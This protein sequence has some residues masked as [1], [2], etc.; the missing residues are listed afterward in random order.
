MRPTCPNWPT[1][2]RTPASRI[3]PRNTRKTRK[4]TEEQARNRQ[5]APHSRWLLSLSSFVS[6]VYF[7]VETSLLRGAIQRGR[8][9]DVTLSSPF[10]CG[11]L[12]LAVSR[13]LAS[14]FASHSPGFRFPHKAS[15]GINLIKTRTFSGT[16]MLSL[17][18]RSHR[19]FCDGHSRR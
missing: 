10:G 3:E 8:L 6:F 11:S 5:Q 19:G 2:R 4:K 14:P 12:R 7:V 18:G 1:R 17:F 9:R 15:P 13:S 16:A